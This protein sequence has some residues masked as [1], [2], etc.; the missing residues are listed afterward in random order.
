MPAV[1]VETSADAF[2]GVA[3][4]ALQTECCNEVWS[5]DLPL[6]NP[7]RDHHSPPEQGGP[8]I[9][10][11]HVTLEEQAAIAYDV[12]T[13]WEECVG[14]FDAKRKKRRANFSWEE[15]FAD[16]EGVDVLQHMG[17][18]ELRAV[19][20]SVGLEQTEGRLTKR[21]GARE[22]KLA[23]AAET[24]AKKGA[25]LPLRLPRRR[26]RRRRRL[27]AAATAAGTAGRSGARTNTRGWREKVLK[28]DN[29]G[30]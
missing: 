9:T 24:T 11:Q 22:A 8:K 14:D 7:N 17:L 3:T 20:M 26:G 28:N 6:T 13:R 1:E 4:A 12:A 19:L 23:A 10:E 15:R 25:A 21:K 5:L 30:D 29:V 16:L 18:E 27:G 2:S